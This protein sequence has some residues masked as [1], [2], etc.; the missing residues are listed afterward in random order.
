MKRK[1]ITA[2]VLGALVLFE[3]L[4]V[5]KY[6]ADYNECI[7]DARQEK[8]ENAR[9]ELANTLTGLENYGTVHARMSSGG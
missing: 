5:K 2:I 4:T 6:A 7:T 1:P 9:P 3:I 8:N